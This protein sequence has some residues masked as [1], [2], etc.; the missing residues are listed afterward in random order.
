MPLPITSKVPECEGVPPIPEQPEL[1]EDELGLGEENVFE[2]M[3]LLYPEDAREF[4]EDMLGV[5]EWGIG[6][7]R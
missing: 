6:R 7:C 4:E 5:V 2:E 3:A 1:Y